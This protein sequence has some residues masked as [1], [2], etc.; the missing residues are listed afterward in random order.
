M[1]Q[2]FLELGNRAAALESFRRALRLY[3][4]LE[5]VRV[6]VV[7]LGRSAEGT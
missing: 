1:G 3:P 7:R 6:Q 4:D 2:A 5:S